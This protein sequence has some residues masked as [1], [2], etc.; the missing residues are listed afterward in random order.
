LKHP[1]YKKILDA[2]GP[3]IEAEIAKRGAGFSLLL[4]REPVGKW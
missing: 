1:I 2:Y 3:E 4:K